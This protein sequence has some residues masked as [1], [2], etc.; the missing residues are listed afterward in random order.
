[1]NFIA[2]ILYKVLRNPVMLDG[3]GESLVMWPPERPSPK[4]WEDTGFTG[5]RTA[6]LDYMRK[7]WRTPNSHFPIIRETFSFST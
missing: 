6:C 1:M 4:G 3:V 5:S 2:P 7:R